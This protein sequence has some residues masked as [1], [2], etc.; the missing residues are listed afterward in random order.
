V[1][2]GQGVLPCFDQDCPCQI[3]RPGTCASGARRRA[4]RSAVA[5]GRGSPALALDGAPGHLLDCGLEQNAARALAH[6]TKGSGGRSGL[7]GGRH[8][9]GAARLLR[10]ARGGA[11][12]HEIKGNWAG[13]FAHR[14][15]RKKAGSKMK[16]RRRWGSLAMVADRAALRCGRGAAA[17][18]VGDRNLRQHLLVKLLATPRIKEKERRD[19]SFTGGDELTAAAGTRGSGTGKLGLTCVCWCV[20]EAKGGAGACA[21]A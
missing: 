15:Q 11:A 1:D 6:V 16:R 8:R 2:R 17:T 19:Q 7:T 10:R 4:R 3:R 14:V 12:V 18:G 9:K 13:V 5:R 20:A 21:R